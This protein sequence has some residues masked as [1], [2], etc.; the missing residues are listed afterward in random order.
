MDHGLIDGVGG[1]IGE[2]AGGQAGHQ[3]LDTILLAEHHDVVLHED[4]L[5]PELNLVF[6]I[7]R[8][9]SLL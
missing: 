4:V 2:D 9:P 3:L 1:L 8:M 6:L 7:T 5:P